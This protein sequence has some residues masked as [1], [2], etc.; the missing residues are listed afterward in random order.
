MT[1]G[2][3]LNMIT[4]H[5]EQLLFSKLSCGMFLSWSRTQGSLCSFWSCGGQRRMTLTSGMVPN[6]IIYHFEHLLFSRLSCSMLLSWSRT[7]GSLCSFWS[8]G[9]QGRMTLTSMMVPNM[10]FCHLEQLLFSKQCQKW[11]YLEF[12]VKFSSQEHTRPPR[13]QEEK[14]GFDSKF[15]KSGLDFNRILHPEQY[16]TSRKPRE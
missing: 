1:S 3:V 8:C 7:K 16:L 11:L 15:P 10:F 9:G 2:M 13:I 14:K 6:M 12:A 4:Y 5:F